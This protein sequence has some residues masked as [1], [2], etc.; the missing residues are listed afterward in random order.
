[1]RTVR[2]VRILLRSGLPMMLVSRPVLLRNG[3]RWPHVSLVVLLYH[4]FVG[5]VVI[6]LAGND[7]L[8]FK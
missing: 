2:P 6:I 7:A 4:R 5:L 8:L 3:S 1:M